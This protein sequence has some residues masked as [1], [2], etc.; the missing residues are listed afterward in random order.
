[1]EGESGIT[2]SSIDEVYPW[3]MQG[4]QVQGERSIT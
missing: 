4:D 1:M 3:D 2:R